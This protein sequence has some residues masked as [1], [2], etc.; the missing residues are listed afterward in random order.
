MEEFT[1]LEI[2][3]MY[4]R[5]SVGPKMLPCG[6]P[7]AGSLMTDVSPWALKWSSLMIFMTVLVAVRVSGVKY[8]LR[9]KNGYAWSS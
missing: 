1:Q 6:T 8:R 3:F 5:K 7:E 2:S 9:S 4:T